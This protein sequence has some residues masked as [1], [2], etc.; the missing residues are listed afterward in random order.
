MQRP[1]LAEVTGELRLVTGLTESVVRRMLRAMVDANERRLDGITADAQEIARAAGELGDLFARRKALARDRRVVKR[2][3]AS[4]RVCAELERLSHSVSYVA[5]RS[6]SMLP[7]S[8]WATL[9]DFSRLESLLPIMV[10]RAMD[11][12]GRED[13]ARATRILADCQEVSAWCLSLE[14]GMS[15]TVQHESDLARAAGDAA[16]VSH[17][18]KRINSHLFAIAALTLSLPVASDTSK[19][20]PAISTT[21]ADGRHA[22]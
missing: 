18:I 3:D 15:E 11:A 20:E 12:F 6:S 14:N 1:E 16:I 7:D 8:P 2:L 13:V 21:F 19:T 10:E 17:S 22:A 4:Y 5:H 9:A